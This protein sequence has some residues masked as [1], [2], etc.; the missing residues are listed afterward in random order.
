MSVIPDNRA[1][2]QKIKNKQGSGYGVNMK[3]ADS[4]KGSQQTIED[5]RPLQ[6]AKGG[7]NIY[8]QN[9]GEEERPIQPM[10]GNDIYS[11]ELQDDDIDQFGRLIK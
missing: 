1:Y 9:Q 5:D 2:L 4:A 11:G 6:G 3:K 8:A 7:V 10:K